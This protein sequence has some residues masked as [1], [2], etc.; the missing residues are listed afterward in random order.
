MR[1]VCRLILIMT[2]SPGLISHSQLIQVLVPL[3][4][5]DSTKFHFLKLLARVFCGL[6]ATAFYPEAS[7]GGAQAK[8]NIMKNVM[9]ITAVAYL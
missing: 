3:N 2:P 6:I 8:M 7:I 4:V 5:T 1:L 9:L